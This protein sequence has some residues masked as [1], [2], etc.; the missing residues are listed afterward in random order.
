M[1]RLQRTQSTFQSEY[2]TRSASAEFSSSPTAT[3]KRQPEPD[4][5]KAITS[6]DRYSL[7]L[8]GSPVQRYPFPAAAQP[9]CSNVQTTTLVSV[10]V[11]RARSERT[12][13]S[14]NSSAANRLSPSVAKNR[15]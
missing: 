2:A 7:R 4:A 9:S 11:H 13:A 3:G 5:E 14:F 15:D 12:E 1:R 8:T 10:A 6:C